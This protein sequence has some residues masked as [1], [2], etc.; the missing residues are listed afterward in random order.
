MFDAFVSGCRPP[1]LLD[2]LKAKIANGRAAVVAKEEEN[3]MRDITPISRRTAF[4]VSITLIAGGFATT[5]ALAQ[6]SDAGKMAKSVVQ[7]R[8]HPA[9]NGAHCAI[10]ANYLPP[11][12]PGKDAHCKLV[13][14]VI[15]P[16]GYCLAFA[17]IK[18]KAS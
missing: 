7:Y 11:D 17:A 16:N 12:A 3:L 6:S 15:D 8:Y 9:A 4:K 2:T 13:A 14:G 1:I 10:C 5:A 18:K